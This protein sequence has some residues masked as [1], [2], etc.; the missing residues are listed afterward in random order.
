MSSVAPVVL[1]TASP[2]YESAR[3]SQIARFDAVRPRGGALAASVLFHV[4]AERD[5]AS[6]SSPSAP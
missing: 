2:E 1:T 6:V 3:R 4:P 5:H